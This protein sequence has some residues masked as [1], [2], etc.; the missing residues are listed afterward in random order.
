MGTRRWMV[1]LGVALTAHGGL[2]LVPLAGRRTP[3]MRER[4]P[5]TDVELV[6][7]AAHPRPLVGREPIEAVLVRE[8]AVEGPSEPVAR[9]ALARPRSHARARSGVDARARSA[10]D[11]QDVIVD[12]GS[13]VPAERPAEQPAG[14]ATGSGLSNMGAPPSAPALLTPGSPAPPGPAAPGTLPGAERMAYAKRVRALVAAHQRYPERARRRGL[15]GDVMLSLV[16]AA[17]GSM[18]RE[19]RVTRSSGVMALDR[20]A[21]RMA[22]RAAPFPVS[23][24]AEALEIAIPVRFSV[25]D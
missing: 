15:Q 11:A 7:V 13:L 22:R 20:E 4:M 25:A 19:P 12:P 24:A 5:V 1:A 18:A 14:Q 17:D 8:P 2:L 21:V 10:A 6:Y 16:I 3:E 9:M 23:G